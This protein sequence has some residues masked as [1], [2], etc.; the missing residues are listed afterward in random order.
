MAK[1]VFKEM[2]VIREGSTVRILGNLFGEDILVELSIL[3]LAKVFGT[4]KDILGLVEKSFGS[5]EYERE[6]NGTRK[7]VRSFPDIDVFDKEIEFFGHK[8][9]IK[10]SLV[11]ENRQNNLERISPFELETIGI[12]SEEIVGWNNE[13]LRIDFP[14]ELFNRFLKDKEIR[15]FMN[16]FYLDLR[17]EQNIE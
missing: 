13:G 14:K 4:D 15:I 10:N 17:I 2:N 3:Q 8:F 16:P 5:E 11:D 1:I 7:Y 6:C 9:L 12:Y